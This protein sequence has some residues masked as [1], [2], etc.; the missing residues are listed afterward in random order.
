MALF[1]FDEFSV[2]KHWGEICAIRFAAVYRLLLNEIAY[3]SPGKQ[4]G[5]D[6]RIASSIAPHVSLPGRLAQGWREHLNFDLFAELIDA[7]CQACGS[8]GLLAGHA[9]RAHRAAGRASTYSSSII[10]GQ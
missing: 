9:A 3:A 2:E 4:V 6:D 10:L 7:A 5:H 1:F 8:G